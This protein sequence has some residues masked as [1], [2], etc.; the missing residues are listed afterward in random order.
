MIEAISMVIDAGCR[1]LLVRVLP[2]GEVGVYGEEEPIER[3]SLS[4]FSS[5]LLPI[6]II[7][8]S[9]HG[10][11]SLIVN[12]PILFRDHSG[13]GFEIRTVEPP[14]VELLVTDGYSGEGVPGDHAGE[15]GVPSEG[16]TRL[17]A[18]FNIGEV[19][20]EP[21]VGH[22]GN[23]SLI[24]FHAA[25]NP[26]SKGPCECGTDEPVSKEGVLELT[27]DLTLVLPWDSLGSSHILPSAVTKEGI[28]SE[29]LR[30]PVNIGDFLL[31]GG[32]TCGLHFKDGIE[33]TDCLVLNLV[34][35][36]IVS[37]LRERMMVGVVVMGRHVVYIT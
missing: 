4:V 13:E 7:M 30:K 22:D 35:F 1:G 17:S 19:M 2:E 15:E 36:A 21:L 18:G 14:G 37:G 28:A 6:F 10:F 26:D 9:E 23:S 34:L 33:L 31:S 8:G 20:D 29:V 12:F 32:E 24:T 5:L 16:Q 11:L 3:R 27:F 25:S